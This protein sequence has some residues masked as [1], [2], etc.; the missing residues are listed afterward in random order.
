MRERGAHARIAIAGA[1][2][3]DLYRYLLRE[4]LGKILGDRAG[5]TLIIALAMGDQGGISSD[6]WRVMTHTGTNHLLAISGLHIGF[7]AGLVFLLVR[8]IW[9]LLGAAADRIA[10]QRVAAL[11]ALASA[12]IYSALAGFS[13]PTQRTLIMIG[14]WS[15]VQMLDRRAGMSEVLA[16]ALLAVLIFDPFSVLAPGFWLSLAAVA[17]IAWG[18]GCRIGKTGV[19][20]RWGRVQV[21]VSVGLLP[22]LVLWFQQVPLLSIPTN[23]I[24]VPWITLVTVPLVLLACVALAFSATLAEGILH[25]ALVSID[26]VWRFLEILSDLNFS[27]L[28]VPSP[29]VPALILAL[30]GAAILLAPRGVPGRWLGAAWMLPLLFPPGTGLSTGELRLALLDVGQGLA[31]V[32]RTRQHTLL[33][34]TGPRFS[35][36][37]SAGRAAVLPYLRHAGTRRVDVLVQ[38]HGDNDHIGGLADVLDG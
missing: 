6:Q 24:A 11:A 35:G 29:G 27:L 31:A 33:Y 19:W 21:V 34:D 8:W 37:F 5:G 7:V 10:A 38:S 4:R 23:L 32:V 12:A 26:M 16:L 25:T 9:P 18:M 36:D 28:P 22:L 15:V 2:N 3:I 13:V 20:W 30:I 14:T 1:W 17:A